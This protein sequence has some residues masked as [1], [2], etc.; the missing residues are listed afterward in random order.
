M[1]SPES[2]GNGERVLNAESHMPALRSAASDLAEGACSYPLIALR[3]C[4]QEPNM[5][6]QGTPRRQRRSILIGAAFVC[7]LLLVLCSLVLRKKDM[8]TPTATARQPAAV[9][10][11]QQRSNSHGEVTSAIDAA[12]R[13]LRSTRDPAE[14]QAR[15]EGLRRSL[16]GLPPN[17]AAAGIRA[18]LDSKADAASHGQFK[19]GVGGFLTECPSLRVFLLDY[20]AQVDSATAASYAT[21]VLASMESPDEWAVALRSYARGNSISESR[22]FLEQKFKAMLT[23]EPWVAE[24]SAGFLEAFDVAVYVGGTTLVPEMADLVRR[25]N[26]QP[27]AHAAYLALDRLTIS[28]AAGT[29]A[30]FQ[31]DPHLLQG[32]EATRAN[33]FARADVR[34]ARQLQVLEEYLL[35]PA[36]QPAELE[37]FAGLYPN[38][39]FM[40]SHN[41]LTSVATPDRAWLTARDA[42]ALRLVQQWLAE[43]RFERLKPPLETIRHRLETFVQQANRSP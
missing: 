3:V 22:S 23:H 11:G 18:F 8:D 28:D 25:T 20:L 43:P 19:V 2:S 35:N 4:V 37:R 38:A 14:A 26:N 39:N 32:R 15:L 12:L 36:I 27:V 40:V 5:N 41:L 31:A 21:T 33:Y 30:T 6:F 9:A 10:T 16:Q 1:K 24:P 42:A 34:D 13:N 17:V 29:L 7:V